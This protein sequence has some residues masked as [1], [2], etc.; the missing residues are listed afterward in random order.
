M[1]K[2]PK[3]R[4]DSRDAYG[5]PLDLR[6]RPS[7]PK[8]RQAIQQEQHGALLSGQERKMLNFLLAVAYPDLMKTRSHHVSTAD[9]R[10]FLG[11]HESNDRIRTIFRRLGRIIPDM[12]FFENG[13]ARDTFGG[14]ISGSIPKGE[15]VIRFSFHPCLVPI[16]HKPAVFARIKLAI[17]GQFVSKYAPILYENLELYA[18]RENKEWRV[19]VDELRSILGVG[20]K[21]K[22]FNQFRAC[23]ITPALQEIN[24]KSDFTVTVDEFRAIRGTGRKVEEL[25]FFVE[26]KPEREAEEAELRHKLKGPTGLLKP[27][28]SRNTDTPDMF[29][30]KT[31]K[32]RGGLPLLKG[33][34]LIAAR[35]LFDDWDRDRPDIYHL[36]DEWRGYQQGR[37]FPRDPD[38]AFLAW[39]RGYKEKREKSVGPYF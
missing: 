18:N 28:K 37:E 9:I 32:E 4:K 21:L 30:D 3:P 8:A 29:D 20:D 6:T 25:V 15:G 16:L 38:K 10:A 13:E 23:A 14:L 34:T 39:V 7:V 19:T 22:K 24:D 35:A 12:T 5:D 31:D 26:L 27:D 36:E 33:D 2:P 11:S 17:L 1:D